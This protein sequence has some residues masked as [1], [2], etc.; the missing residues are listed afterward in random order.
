MSKRKLNAVAAAALAMFVAAGCSSGAS[1]VASAAKAAAD[2]AANPSQAPGGSTTTLAPK[3][4]TL[5]KTVW[6]G[7]QQDLHLV[8][9]IHFAT[10]LFGSGS[11]IPGSTVPGLSVPAVPTL[12]V[13]FDAENLQSDS[14]SLSFGSET[15]ITSHGKTATPSGGNPITMAANA[16]ASGALTFQVDPSFSLDDAVLQLGGS[17]TNTSTVPFAASAPVTTFEPKTGFATGKLAGP[18]HD[19]SILASRLYADTT[20]GQKGK[21]VLVIEMRA[22]FK[23]PDAGGGGLVGAGD[24]SLKSPDGST[25]PGAGIVGESTAPLNANLKVGE[26]SPTQHVGFEI[27]QPIG[28]SYSLTYTAAQGS[29]QDQ[30]AQMSFT[31]GQ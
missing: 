3:T 14:R 17:D 22:T 1:K 21:F 10:A 2:A 16:T 13:N 24:F 4:V 26:T 23:G 20:P 31:V 11:A 29:L 19:F 6:W 28:G 12:T 9:K 25:T 18:D 15:T 27:G 7:V 8:F 5:N 30:T